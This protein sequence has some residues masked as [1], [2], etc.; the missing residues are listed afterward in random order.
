M[1]YFKCIYC[2]EIQGEYN[3]AVPQ[4][5]FGVLAISAGLLTLCMPE[6]FKQ[7]LSDTIEEGETFG[8]DQRVLCFRLVE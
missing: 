2:F 7:R 3:R 8:K 6:T 5:I 4:I 1:K